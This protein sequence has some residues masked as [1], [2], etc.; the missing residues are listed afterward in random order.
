[1][2]FKTWNYVCSINLKDVD[3]TDKDCPLIE[4]IN[5]KEGTCDIDGFD[6]FCSSSERRKE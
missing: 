2:Q 4:V 6:Y 5:C 1:M 3:C